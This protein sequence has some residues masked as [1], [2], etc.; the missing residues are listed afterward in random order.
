MIQIKNNIIY[1]IFIKKNLNFIKVF[2]ITLL[3]KIIFLY[4]LSISISFFSQDKMEE[5]KDSLYLYI[6]RI[7]NKQ[8]SQ[9]VKER[10]AKKI[11]VFSKNLDDSS[12]FDA[13]IQTAL[14]YFK[15]RKLDSLKKYSFIAKQNAVELNDL[16]RIQKAHFYLATYYKYK[17]IPDSAYYHYNTSK[18]ILLKLGDTITAGRRMLNFAI[19]QMNEKDL[20]GSEIT[21]IT[22]LKYLEKSNLN[23]I[24]ADLYNNLALI[25]KKRNENDEALKYLDLSLNYLNKCEVNDNV[26]KSKLNYF[27]NSA[28]IYQKKK[29]YKKA[30]TFLEKALR[31]DSIKEKFP[32]SYALILENMTFNNYKLNNE[33]NLLNNYKEVLA[34]RKKGND[35]KSFSATN[36]ILAFYF[37]DKG[38]KEKA[39]FYAKEGLKYSKESKENDRH[40]EALKLLSELT[41]G[42]TSNNYL[43]QY[44]Q[45]NDSLF[46]RERTLKN[47]FAKIRYETEKKEKENTNLKIENDRKQLE[48]QKEKQQKTI[49]W[50]TAGASILFIAFGLSIASSRRK[51]LLFNAKLKQ[52]EARENERRQIAKSL[53]DEVAGDI[54]MLHL[55]LAKSSQ[56]EEAKR[57]DIIK[58]NVRNLS[59][60]LSSES[61]NDVSFKDQVINLVSDFFDVEFKILV[62]KIDVIN[63]KKIDN[64]IK[65]TLFL[66]I[67][68]SIQNAKKH[69]E[70]TKVV[71]SFSETKK[72]VFLKIKDNGKGFNTNVK[73]SG[74]GLKNIKERIEEINGVFTIESVQEKGTESTIEIPKNGK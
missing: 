52:V 38:N 8:L 69:A 24:K 66:S 56:L 3:K 35:L 61:F 5:N 60:Q 49:G 53:H 57:L 33:K 13:N 44:I 9:E 37:R 32:L 55:K 72:T 7:K 63:W 50:M 31:I 14:M 64:S 48:I 73:R 6:N 59:H 46:K 12:K 65:R 26:I 22:S 29:E 4:F 74:I 58:E 19:I 27:N 15:K 34:L 40:L 18:N 62:E 42:E 67:R 20:L 30:N 45:L 36:N 21:T 70:A 16:Q 10:Y 28:L 47:Q 1:Y 71:L 11:L 2:Y 54:R 39:L 25:A 23:R 68:E 43:Q 51:K 17:E 41:K